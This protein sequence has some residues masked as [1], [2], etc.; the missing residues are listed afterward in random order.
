VRCLLKWVEPLTLLLAAAVAGFVLASSL[1]VGA[2][3][4]AI[5]AL[6]GCLAALCLCLRALVARER[7]IARRASATERRRIA[8]DLHDGIAQE[9]AFIAMLSKGLDD[10]GQDAAA[11]SH[12]RAAAARALQDSRA[13]IGV[14]TSADDTP[15][16]GLVTRTVGTF[17]S[18]FG[19]QV[20]LD[21]DRDLVV[22]AERR[23]AL[24]RILQEALNNAVRHGE[25]RRI[26]VRLRRDAGS[27][28]LSIADDGGGFD[29]SAAS[30]N[31][32]G[33]GLVSMRERAEQLG[34]GV[35][36]VSSPGAGTRV[37]VR[38]P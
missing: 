23:D 29:A 16:D 2:L 9:L 18:R 17:R 35:S 11:V 10:A 4:L 24:I 38:L 21:L 30:G 1:N 15:L 19:V 8:R 27:S 36:V 37:E 5:V 7:R 20:D 28:L 34:G 22:D 14:L 32:D 33:F 25:P 3:G 13:S 31:G 6:C 12:L 26:G